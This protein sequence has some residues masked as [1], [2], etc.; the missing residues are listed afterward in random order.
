MI[1][2]MPIITPHTL[3]NNSELTSAQYAFNRFDQSLKF[4]MFACVCALLEFPSFPLIFCIYV[5]NKRIALIPPITPVNIYFNKPFPDFSL[6][7]YNKFS[8]TTG[9][10]NIMKKKCVYIPPKVAIPNKI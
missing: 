7:K 3:P 9:Q 6:Y 2:H 1:T 10:A 4:L 8:K 5:R